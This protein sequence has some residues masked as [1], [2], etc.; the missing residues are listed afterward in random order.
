MNE[1]CVHGVPNLGL[2]GCPACERAFRNLKRMEVFKAFHGQDEKCTCEECPN[3]ET[4]VCAFDLYNTADDC[5][6]DK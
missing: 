1:P 4:C 2:P 5:L 3:T 6:M